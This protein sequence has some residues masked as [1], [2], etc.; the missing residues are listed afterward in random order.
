MHAQRLL[1]V[2]SDTFLIP[3][4]DM[5]VAF[6]RTCKASSVCPPPVVR[7]TA[8]HA[9]TRLPRAGPFCRVAVDL[10][11]RDVAKKGDRG[12][13]L[14][15]ALVEARWAKEGAADGSVE[16]GGGSPALAASH[17]SSAARETEDGAMA[18]AAAVAEELDVMEEREA[19][20]QAEAEEERMALRAVAE[21]HTRDVLAARW[22]AELNAFQRFIEDTELRAA[23]RCWLLA[24]VLAGAV[25]GQST[26]DDAKRIALDAMRAGKP[27]CIGLDGCDLHSIGES[28]SRK[29]RGG[30]EQTPPEPPLV[31][32][33]GNLG[34]RE[35]VRALRSSRRA[36]AHRNIAEVC[37]RHHLVANGCVSANVA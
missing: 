9:P 8:P 23:W 27:L 20:E 4:R 14:C 29:R 31:Q 10:I 19:E 21:Q 5:C 7:L 13:H 35:C 33:L 2:R 26:P 11:R 36:S 34:L 16:G 32:L 12:K 3:V 17:V 37:V 1:A 25:D 18:A 15:D 30:V 24:C 22:D 28:R 6:P